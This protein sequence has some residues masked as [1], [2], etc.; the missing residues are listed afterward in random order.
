MIMKSVFSKRNFSL[1]KTK[2]NHNLTFMNFLDGNSLRV[3]SDLLEK[4]RQIIT[5]DNTMIM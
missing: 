1:R 4:L 2:T 3:F 5:Y